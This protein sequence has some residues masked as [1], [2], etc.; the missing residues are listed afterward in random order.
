MNVLSGIREPGSRVPSQPPKA[1]IGD[2]AAGGG[3]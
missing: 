3:F 2:A 1:H